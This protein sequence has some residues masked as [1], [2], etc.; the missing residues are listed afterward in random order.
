M[1]SLQNSASAKPPN[2]ANI[3]APAIKAAAS[4][5]KAGQ[6]KNDVPS[7]CVAMAMPRDGIAKDQSGARRK[8]LVHLAPNL[9]PSNKK[10]K[11]MQAC[12]IQTGKP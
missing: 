6:G 9:K 1:P 4:R 3:G 10:H 11:G 8:P 7:K 5:A 12:R 2:T